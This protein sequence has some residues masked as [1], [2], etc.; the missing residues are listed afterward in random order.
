MNLMSQVI[1]GQQSVEEHQ[2][3]IGQRQIILRVL[4]DLLHLPHHVVGKVPNRARC[5]WRQPR[6]ASRALLPQQPLQ[7]LENIFVTL[8]DSARSGE[9]PSLNLHS[10]AGG[11]NPHIRS[12]AQKRIAPNL[13]AAFHRLQQK[14]MRLLV[15]NRQKGRHRRQQIGAYRPHYWYQRGLARQAREFLVIGL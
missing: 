5:E 12:H 7:H 9:L 14:R 2:L 1:E 15:G 4:A 3:R 11:P 10:S 8:L 13:L 6:D